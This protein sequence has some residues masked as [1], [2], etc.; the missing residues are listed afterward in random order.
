MSASSSDPFAALG[1]MSSVGA[2]GQANAAQYA[3]RRTHVRDS[4]R[5]FGNVGRTIQV[6]FMMAEPRVE[7][8]ALRD[9]RRQHGD[10]VLLPMNESRFNCA[11]KPLLWY[12][13]CLEAFPNTRFLA[14]ADDDAYVQL[15]HMEADLRSLPTAERLIMWGLVMWYGA[16][17]NVTMVT[18]EEWG[19][20]GY[21][22]SGAVKTRRRMDRCQASAGGGGTSA[23]G[24]VRKGG[25]APDEG[26]RRRRGRA[27]E[28]GVGGPSAD[29]CSRLN[30]AARATVSR[31][32]LDS[33]TAPWPVVNG[34]LFAVSSAL[35]RLIVSDPLPRRYLD[36]LH[37]TSRVQA[38]L[39]RPGGPRK[40]NF[41][42][43]PVGDS[44]FGLW[45]SQLSERHN[46]SVAIVNT[47]FMVQHHPWPATVHGAFSNSSI[48][49]HGLKKE[50]NQVKFREVV[51]RRGLGPFVPFHRKCGS[52][53][54]M[55]WST[56]P[57][58]VHGRWT[59]CGCDAAAESKR[60][61]DERMAVGASASQEG[62]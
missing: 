24:A 4:L 31:R 19:G 3:S 12:Q 54:A 62:G 57:G 38:A 39:N 6:R 61:C 58:S 44:I 46:E 2:S 49:L 18:H 37:R 48:V 22:D 23:I 51:A 27:S 53:A 10:V 13:H 11:V 52:C 14:I 36:A 45:V 42:C 25:A 32:G 50:K 21:A 1:I 7:S 55:G 43:W 20:W 33:A 15:E 17:D 29:A 28:R 59:C 47:P 30:A 60:T 8:E 26:R 5:W 35:A 41:G 16:Y 40:S 9:E 34:P 56:W